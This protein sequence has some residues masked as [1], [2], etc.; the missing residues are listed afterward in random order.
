MCDRIEL[1]AISENG[2]QTFVQPDA[3][4]AKRIEIHDFLIYADPQPDHLDLPT[5]QEKVEEYLKMR[6]KNMNIFWILF[7]F[8]QIILLQN[9]SFKLVQ[10]WTI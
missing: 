1:F 4:I 5:T 7:L 8:H 2:K 6:Y 9:T 10:I 3:N